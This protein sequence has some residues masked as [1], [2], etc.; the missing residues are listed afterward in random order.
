VTVVTGP[1]GAAVIV[2]SS[3]PSAFSRATYERDAPAMLVKPPPTT[4]LP[5][6]WSA[7]VL[8]GAEPPF[9]E[10]KLP[11]TAPVSL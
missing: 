10:V 11:S 1:F 4:I 7:M 6:V 8:I 5:S 9:T 2:G 3:E